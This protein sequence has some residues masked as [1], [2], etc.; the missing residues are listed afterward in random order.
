MKEK[1]ELL[2]FL[3]VYCQFAIPSFCGLI[4]SICLP[5]LTMPAKTTGTLGT[6][7]RLVRVRAIGNTTR[8]ENTNDCTSNGNDNTN[9]PG[10]RL[11]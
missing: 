5:S 4:K 1:I 9:W 6:S 2:L 10:N 7:Y 3:V 8:N 11:L